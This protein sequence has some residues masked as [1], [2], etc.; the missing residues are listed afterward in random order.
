[1]RLNFIQRVESD[2]EDDEEDERRFASATLSIDRQVIDLLQEA[3][4]DGLRNSV[5]LTIFRE[6]VRYSY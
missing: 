2:D 5:R 1:M 6:S 4:Q 3:G